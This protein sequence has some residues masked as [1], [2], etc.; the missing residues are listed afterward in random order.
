MQKSSL[1]CIH[2]LI[3]VSFRY[4][5]RGPDAYDC[6]GLARECW[7]RWH[8]VELPEYR[9]STLPAENASEFARAAERGWVR[10]EAP[11]PGSLV[12]MR[13]HGF[14]AHVG[15]VH[16]QTRLLQ[17]LEGLGVVESRI[18]T[19]RRQIIGAYHHDPSR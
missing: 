17:A 14:G 13:I 11:R 4:G 16:S 9:S 19:Y 10:L 15:F 12:L 3:G 1:T 5:A 2:D 6:W 7:W 8:G 18:T